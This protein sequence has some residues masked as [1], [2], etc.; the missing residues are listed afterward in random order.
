ML[1]HRSLLWSTDQGAIT[2]PD[3]GEHTPTFASATSTVRSCT[4]PSRSATPTRT[5]TSSARSMGTGRVGKVYEGVISRYEGKGPLNID[6]EIE[7]AR[8][9]GARDAPIAQDGHRPSLGAEQ[10]CWRPLLRPNVREC[11]L[12]HDVLGIAPHNWQ[13]HGVPTQDA[14]C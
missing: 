3:L 9:A 5:S 6:A 14:R 7:I 1:Q 8:E 2:H 4:A 10:S 13:A 12:V 11:P